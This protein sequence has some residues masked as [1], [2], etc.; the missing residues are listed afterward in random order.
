MDHA[1]NLA[2]ESTTE[3]QELA[4][5]GLLGFY[6][7]LRSRIARAVERRGGRL[8]APLARYLLLVPDVFMLLARLTLDPEV[9]AATRRLFG[10]ALLYFVV[11]FDLL[12]EALTGV[13]GYVDDL[14]LASAVLA[15]ALGPGLEGRARLHWSGDE[16]LRRVLSDVA[17]SA[18]GLLGGGLYGRLRTV[19]ESRGVSLSDEP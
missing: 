3:P 19:L 14:V 2:N 11:P 9:P 18:R 8:G 15:Q 5:R 17:R 12:P 13:A 4:S 7:G 1:L 16:D 10:G 6:D